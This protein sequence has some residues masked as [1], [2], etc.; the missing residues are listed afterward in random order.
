MVTLSNAFEKSRRTASTCCF[1]FSPL[2][3]SST[4]MISCVSYDL[5]F[6]NPCW[7]SVNILWRSKWLSEVGAVKLV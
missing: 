3:R 5:R 7:Q 6:L 2:A 1:S 4:V